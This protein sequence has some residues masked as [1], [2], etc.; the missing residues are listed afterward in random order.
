[1][2][3]GEAAPKVAIVGA[4]RR[5]QGTGPFIA[6]ELHRLGCRIQ[7]VVGTS[8]ASVDDARRALAGNYGIHCAGHVDL[9]RLLAAEPIDAVAICSPAGCH[10]AHLEIALAAGCHVFCEK[11]LWWDDALLD[12]SPDEVEADVRGL[13]ARG[14]RPGRILALN[15][16]WPFTLDVFRALH[17]GA[18]DGP[19]ERFGMLLSPISTDAPA[20]VDSAP[21]LLSMVYALAGPGRIVTPR[22]TARGAA[23]IT[24]GFGYE[25]AGGATEVELELRTCAE[26]PRPV[27]YHVNGRAV[28]RRVELDGYRM[29]LEDG[30]RAVALS[31]PLAR[32]VERFVAAIRA[33]GPGDE[34]AIV[35]GMVQLR[36]LVA[37]VEA[38]VTAR[39]GAGDGA[40]RPLA[41]IHDFAGKLL[42]P[43][44]MGR[45]K[46]YVRWQSD[47]RG[48]RARGDAPAMEALPA[49][50]PLSINLD[51]TTACNYRCDHCVDFD[52]LNTG[53]SF[54]HGKLRDSLAAM[55]ARGLRSVIVIGGGEPT[56]YPGFADIV[57]FMKDLG[58][59]LGIVTNG[60]RMEKVAEIVHRLDAADW[61]R[62]SLD[63][64]T[65]A[66]FQALHLPRRPITLEEI[67]AHV[68]RLKAINPQPRIG[69]SFIVMWRGCAVR[70]VSLHENVGEIAAAAELAR[71]HRFDYISIKPFLTRAEAN[72]AE[73]VEL[74]GSPERARDVAAEIH[75]EVTRARALATDGFAVIESTNLRALDGAAD[76][77]F[78]R[79]PRQCHMQFFRQVV[80]PLGVY[81]CP[82]YRNVAHA[83][84]G[85]RHAYGTPDGAQGALRSTFELIQRF[86]AAEE[87]KDVTCLY[88]PANWAIEELI[89]H[90]ERLDGLTPTAERGDYYL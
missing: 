35:A 74:A 32:S 25:H 87:C 50:A 73:I 69:F 30:A 44:T 2:G 46:E 6:R 53:I 3:E 86:D 84:V 24:L 60:S 47:A 18:L 65:D 42:Q 75:A 4:A 41:P 39:A 68:P 78:R 71:R 8:T 13:L 10:R 61:I 88:N 11:P 36:E 72:N 40:S 34:E 19:L 54:D 49:Y 27:R 28:S 51:L 31:D 64:G 62:L 37:C 52:N 57:G 81:N 55:T 23:A 90:P 22:V 76:R 83:R 63:A 9:E 85:E 59:Q 79:Q 82:V 17:P 77:P 45:L 16:Q 21:H 67:C 58:L 14:A 29:W 33:G 15:T 43:S 70:D 5:R 80:S 89:E 66:S 38:P 20:V 56:V 1:M 12:R 26:P 7:A 48:R